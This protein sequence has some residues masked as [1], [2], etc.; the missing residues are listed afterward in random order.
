MALSK[1]QDPQYITPV[2]NPIH[3]TLSA[4]TT[5]EE[6]FRYICYL[7][8]C[9]NNLLTTITQP[10][11]PDNQLGYFNLQKLCAAYVNTTKPSKKFTQIAKSV[12]QACFTAK[13]AE[14]YTQYF[15]CTSVQ[16][17]GTPVDGYDLIFYFNDGH[18]FNVGDII[19]FSGTGEIGELYNNTWQVIQTPSNTTI[20]VNGM[21]MGTANSATTATCVLASH[22]RTTLSA[23]TDM[24]Y[25]F[26]A[27][28]SALDTCDF[29]DYKLEYYDLSIGSIGWPISW[30]GNYPQPYPIRL[31][32]YFDAQFLY[33]QSQYPANSPNA[34][35]VRTYDSNGNTYVY[36]SPT[37]NDITYSGSS[38]FLLPIG[39]SNLNNANVTATWSAAGGAT[40]PIIKPS[41]LSYD[42]RLRNGVLFATN[43][44]TFTMDDSCSKYIN[45]EINFLDR[46]GNYV[47]INFT[48]VQRKNVSVQRNTFKKSLIS[49][50]SSSG[51]Y[52]R[53]DDRGLT[54]LNNVIQYTYTL[55]TDW[56]SESLS[57][58]FEQL[59]TSPNVF[60]NYEGT[61]TMLPVVLT[62]NAVDV[63]DKKNSRLIQYSI[64][65][66][67]SNNPIVQQG[68]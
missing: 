50:N 40:F 8:D 29:L 68:S 6:N 5:S 52:Y 55:Q 54:I 62:T 28:N 30:Y 41:T 36:T 44:L 38:T 27:N 63:L 37:I 16:I 43:T 57:L 53:C 32:N 33:S 7:Y 48:L 58:Y 45:Y 34:I 39:P 17:D 9:D 67:P 10:P 59:I 65:M 46:Y 60:W 1:I 18:E 15:N 22:Q 25:E 21:N 2:Y 4:S 56:M 66:T 13:F 31:T 64:T 47:P 61:G 35:V 24:T 51:G 20:N 49:V 26:W 11:R 42:V 12:E 19:S 14:S 3:F 23:Q